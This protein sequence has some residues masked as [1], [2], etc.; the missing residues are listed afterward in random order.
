MGRKGSWRAAGDLVVRRGAVTG[1]A[2]P[3]LLR[4]RT[5]DFPAAIGLAP[6]RIPIGAV[7]GVAGAVTG[8]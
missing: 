6:A 2:R 5:G 1:F 4:H 3:Q 8:I 7:D